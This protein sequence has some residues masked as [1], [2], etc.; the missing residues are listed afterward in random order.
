M[1]VLRNGIKTYYPKLTIRSCLAIDKLFGDV[2]KPL[3]TY[4]SVETQVL[5]LALSLQQYKLT[6]DELYDL[7][8]TV[9]DVNSL[10]LE[11]YKEDGLISLGEQQ[12]SV[13]GD[14]EPMSD[15]PSESITFES[16]IMNLLQQ[17]MSIGMREEDFYNSTLAQITRYV[18]SY[19]KQQQNK[20][21]EKAYF[22]YQLA[23]LI[24]V[25]VS[26]LLSKNAKYPAFEKVYPFITQST[27]AKD[28]NEE[29]EMEV[30]RN[31]LCEWAEQM[32]KKFN[33]N[34][35]ELPN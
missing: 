9:D 14:F 25:S 20:L 16:H 28:I 26:R 11:L 6:E 32:N 1:V 12:N 29:W 19:N 27:Q 8:D 21:Q 30:Q 3:F 10:V 35:K 13:D 5:L 31:R 23:N 17:C 33:K 18:E 24:G 22:D 34:K 15:T 7:M 4:I 2:T